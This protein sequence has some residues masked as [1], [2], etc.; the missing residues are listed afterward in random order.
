MSERRGVPRPRA[1]GRSA[2]A[3][4]R[5]QVADHD[6]STLRAVR[7][8]GQ[9]QARAI[10]ERTDRVGSFDENRAPAALVQRAT[11]L[12]MPLQT[13]MPR[14]PSIPERTAPDRNE[15]TAGQFRDD[16]QHEADLFGRP[17]H[18]ITPDGR[19]GWAIPAGTGE[20]IIPTLAQAG[21]LSTSGVERAGRRGDGLVH[22][23]RA[24][25]A[26][27][28]PAQGLGQ[29]LA[30]AVSTELVEIEREQNEAYGTW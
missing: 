22:R 25:P 26:G 6:P 2:S 14:R 28:R 9:A 29:E 27:D 19:S 16:A 21:I 10:G 7:P 23:G 20:L 5:T 1:V 3:T 11:A 12:P 15:Q 30:A 13:L 18:W 4:R 8:A 24:Q 17:V